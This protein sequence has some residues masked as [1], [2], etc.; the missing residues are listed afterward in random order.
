[1]CHDRGVLWRH[2]GGSNSQ[3]IKPQVCEKEQYECC[4]SAYQKCLP[5]VFVKYVGKRRASDFSTLK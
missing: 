3:L 5:N 4:A 1:M 2:R